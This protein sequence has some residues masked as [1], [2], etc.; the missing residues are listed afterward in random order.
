MLDEA[1]K[2]NLTLYDLMMEHSSDSAVRF[3]SLPVP[4]ASIDTRRYMAW[5]DICTTSAKMTPTLLTR[6]AEQVLTYYS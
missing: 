2:K 6:G 4:A 5:L 3:M 1:T